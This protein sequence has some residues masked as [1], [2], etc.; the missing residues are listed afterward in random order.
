MQNI[1]A[2]TSL[3]KAKKQKENRNMT[4]DKKN[5]RKEYQRNFQVN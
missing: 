3:K 2:E 4:E 5:K 1:N